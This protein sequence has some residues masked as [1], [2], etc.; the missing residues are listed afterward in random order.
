MRR[1]GGLRKV[2]PITFVTFALGYLAIIGIPPFA[3]FFSKDKIIEAAFGRRSPA[4][5]GVVALLGAGITAFYMTR[6]MLMTFFGEARWT[7]DV[8]PHESPLDHDVPDDRPR[9][10]APPSRGCPAAQRRVR[11]L[12]RAGRPGSEEP[13]PPLAVVVISVADPRARRR[14]RR[15][16][17]GSPY[18]HARRCPRG[19][20]GGHR[21]SPAPP[22]PTSTATP[23]TRPCSCG[24]A[25][26]S[27]AAL[28]WFDNQVVD[29]VVNGTAALVGGLSGRAA[30]AA[31]RLR[32]LLRAVH[33]RR[34]RPG[35]RRPRAGEALT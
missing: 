6:L 29:G 7:D 18:A 31:D 13:E 23:S 15:R 16:S 3:G 21:R 24:P 32:P 17:P 33:A 20:A 30:P 12:A 19:R 4:G 34:R 8:H 1:Y 10:A 27:P 25:S 9:A 11:R 35:R 28:V 26:T 14:R 2:M 5:S 22:A